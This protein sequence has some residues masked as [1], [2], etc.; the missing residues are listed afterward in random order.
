MAVKY[1]FEDPEIREELSRPL[2]QVLGEDTALGRVRGFSGM[3]LS[4]GDVV[5]RTLLEHDFRPEIVVF[6]DMSMRK[7]EV[8]PRHLL[9][10]YEI[11][12]TVNPSGT[13]TEEACEVLKRLISLS[14]QFAV[15]VLGEEDLLGL[16]AIDKAPLGS[17][18]L[19]GQPGHG[20]VVVD[21]DSRSKKAVKSILKRT[22]VSTDG[23]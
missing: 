6:D 22:R 11:R 3:V 20:I 19:Y 8:F 16:P 7:R 15:E 12:R 2:G 5:S 4:V 18:V 9:E 10:G 14:G 13:L 23:N 1:I 21:V 17:L